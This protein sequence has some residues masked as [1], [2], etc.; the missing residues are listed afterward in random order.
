MKKTV[1]TILRLLL[2]FVIFLGLQGRVL[3]RYAEIFQKN[4][5]SELVHT[6]VT[7]VKAGIHHCKLQCY[8]KHFQ[9]LDTPFAALLFTLITASLITDLLYIFLNGKLPIAGSIRLLPLRGPPAF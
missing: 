3:M 4:H 9:V 5:K 1:H 6:E 2:V 8:T 7:K